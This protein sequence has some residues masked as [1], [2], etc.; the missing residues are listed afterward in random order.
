MLLKVTIYVAIY[1]KQKMLYINTYHILFY[2]RHI[3]FYFLKVLY[4]DNAILMLLLRFQT[5]V[6]YSSLDLFVDFVGCFHNFPLQYISR[7]DCI[8]Y[9][10]TSRKL[11]IKLLCRLKRSLYVQQV[12]W[13]CHL[14]KIIYK[15]R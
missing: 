4:I 3:M 13:S 1:S 2:L 5:A 11:Y 10:C 14:G 9:L 15:T 8:S 12:L 6:L 7:V